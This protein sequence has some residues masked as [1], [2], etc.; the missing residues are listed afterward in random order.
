MCL[1]VIMSNN[2]EHYSLHKQKMAYIQ[3][4]ALN[5]H[6]IWSLQTPIITYIVLILRYRLY[7]G[8]KMELHPSPN[9]RLQSAKRKPPNEWWI[10]EP[11]LFFFLTAFLPIVYQTA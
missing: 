3:K 2:H 9:Y 8:T 7:N 1:Y 10:L 6:K 11:I 4:T 5:A